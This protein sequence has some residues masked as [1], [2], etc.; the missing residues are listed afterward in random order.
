VY[1]VASDALTD[2]FGVFVDPDVWGSASGEEVFD[3]FAQHE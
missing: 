1:L 3:Y 2:D